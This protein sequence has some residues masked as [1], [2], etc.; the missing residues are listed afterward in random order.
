MGGLDFTYEIPTDFK[1]G[2][3][4]FFKANGKLNIAQAITKCD[5]N[6]EDLGYAY[7]AGIK[8]N[9]WNKKALDI[10]IV[11]DE[12]SISTLKSHGRMVSEWIQTYLK[13]DTSG[14][15][16]KNIKYFVEEDT[17]ETIDLM[18]PKTDEINFKVLYNDISDALAKDEPVLVLDRLHTY[19]VKYLR[20]LCQKYAIPISDNNKFYPLH[21]LV[22]KLVRY[23]ENNG[24]FETDFSK[25]AMKSS[26]SL[27]N[28]YN[29]VRNNK[30]Y[31]HDN[32]VLEN[33]EA[34]YVVRM[35]S[36]TLAF[37]E[38]IENY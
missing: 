2:L 6:Y 4:R 1:Q 36:A 11:G 8:G 33:H 16:I 3:A 15:L 32:K 35:L 24:K 12:H 22:G 10:S 28:S 13:P 26:I 14:Y 7:Y 38:S 9:N 25:M 19:S 31:A 30:S 37:I 18:L 17:S 29:D 27:F 21:D 5:I 20:S 23:Y 34:A